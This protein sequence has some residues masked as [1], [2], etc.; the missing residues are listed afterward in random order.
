MRA[1]R[2]IIIPILILTIV[3]TYTPLAREELSQFWERARPSVLQ[4]ID[5]L[6]IAI[7]NFVAE[8]DMHDGIEDHPPG[9]DYDR[10]ITMESSS[11]S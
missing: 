4:F 8:G 2:L 7:R 5:G 1:V 11:S 9:V 6:Y 10:V 3:F